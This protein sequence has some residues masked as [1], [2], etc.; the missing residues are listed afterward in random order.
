MTQMDQTT[1]LSASSSEEL[2]ATSNELKEQASHL[3]TIM[4]TLVTIDES[5]LLA[6]HKKHSQISNPNELKTLLWNSERLPKPDI[7]SA[8]NNQIPVTGNS[9]SRKLLA[10]M[11]AV[12]RKGFNLRV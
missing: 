11:P 10:R 12:L 7:C 6:S 8:I 5:K 4:G 2:A 3:L 9:R 1:Q